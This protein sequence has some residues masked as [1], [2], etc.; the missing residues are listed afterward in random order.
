MEIALKS[1]LQSAVTKFKKPAPDENQQ[2]KDDLK[3][4]KLSLEAAKSRFELENNDAEIEATI[5][6]MESLS[7]RYRY[8]LHKA[9]EL[10]I[11][12]DPTEN[13]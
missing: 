5:Y 2:L 9:R 1:L 12:G 7:V 13:W 10:H 6:E 3:E 8:L 11:V 4:I